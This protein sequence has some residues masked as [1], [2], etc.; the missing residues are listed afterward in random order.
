MSSRNLI[1]SAVGDHSFHKEWISG[2]PDFD[3]VLIYYGGNDEIFSNYAK[4]ALICIRQ[5]GQKFPLTGAFIHQNLSMT[6]QYEYV[7]LPD[8]DISIS[9]DCVNKLFHVAKEHDLWICQPSVI[10]VDNN[11]SH[12][13]TSPVKNVKLRFTN[14]VEVMM[15]LFKTS[16]LLSLYDD[17]SISESG[18]GLDASWSHRLNDP[19]DR[20]GVIDEITALHTRPVGSDYSRFRVHPQI[21]LNH[22]LHKYNIAFCKKNYSFLFQNNVLKTG[23]FRNLFHLYWEKT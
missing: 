13:I 2:E 16:T 9:T 4:D 22:I 8:D 17:F 20:I 21:E 14:F 18:W 1:I 3:L 11:V 5:K 15:P 10:S 23:W 6:V 7:W 12:A 19:K